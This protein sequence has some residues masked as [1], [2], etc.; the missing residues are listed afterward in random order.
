M[1]TNIFVFTATEACDK[2]RMD[3]A[4]PK[5]LLNAGEFNDNVA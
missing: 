2:Q 5:E 4:S 1:V 3:A